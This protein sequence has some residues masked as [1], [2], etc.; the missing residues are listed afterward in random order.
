MDVVE[1]ADAIEVTLDVPGA[2]ES[3]LKVAFSQNLLMISGEKRPAQ[4]QHDRAAFHLAERSFGR[5]ARGVR[6]TGA[7]DTSRAT[8]VLRAGELRVILPRIAERRG[9]ELVIRVT[10]D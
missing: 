4:C 7:F 9:F 8:A 3:S 1:T 10:V 5:F 6:L 2:V